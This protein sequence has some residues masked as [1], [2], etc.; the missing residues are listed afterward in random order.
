MDLR[1]TD[2]TT[3]GRHDERASYDR[4]TANAILDEGMVAGLGEHDQL[5]HDNSL[6]AEIFY[7]EL[8]APQ[9]VESETEQA[10][11]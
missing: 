2:R 1:Q 11:L 9:P 7:T 5:L 3:I 10:D 4:E 6:Y 8:S